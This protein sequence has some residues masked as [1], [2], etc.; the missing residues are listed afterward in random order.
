MQEVTGHFTIDYR[1]DTL[2]LAN[3]KLRLD[4]FE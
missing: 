1:L 2:K 3:P 4:D